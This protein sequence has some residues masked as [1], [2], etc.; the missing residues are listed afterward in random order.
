MAWGGKRPGAGR[1]RGSTS[2]PLKHLLSAVLDETLEPA[3]RLEAAIAA[4]ELMKHRTKPKPASPEVA[5]AHAGAA[6]PHSI[7]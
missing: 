5:A 6:R 3:E 2:S 4:A 1:P 7:P